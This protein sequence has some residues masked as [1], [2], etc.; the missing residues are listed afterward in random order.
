MANT[1]E[2]NS[3]DSYIILYSAN[4]ERK[5][6][7]WFDKGTG[8]E[9]EIENSIGIRVNLAGTGVDPSDNVAQYLAEALLLVD[10]FDIVENISD[11]EI[12]NVNN[13]ETTDADTPNHYYLFLSY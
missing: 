11:V 8:V 7:I 9:P 1:T 3:N 12:T 4:D 2:T 5:Y 6:H 13:G 10:D